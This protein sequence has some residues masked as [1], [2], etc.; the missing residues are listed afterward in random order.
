MPG[1]GGATFENHPRVPQRLAAASVPS[2][3]WSVKRKH[4]LF[5][6]AHPTRNDHKRN[7]DSATDRI[8]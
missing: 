2:K 1:A 8:I 3:D 6:V 7:Y 5:V 4:F